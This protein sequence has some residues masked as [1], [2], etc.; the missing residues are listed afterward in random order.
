MRGRVLEG[1]STCI[2]RLQRIKTG[3]ILEGEPGAKPVGK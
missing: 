2:L 1:S 3:V